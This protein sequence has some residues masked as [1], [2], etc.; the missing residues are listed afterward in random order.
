MDTD[1][2]D[3]GGACDGTTF[4]FCP[5]EGEVPDW[6]VEDCGDC[7]QNDENVFDLDDCGV[8]GGPGEIEQC[9]DADGDGWGNSIITYIICEDA[10][11]EWV[12]DCT[13]IEDTVYCESNVIVDGTCI[14]LSLNDNLIPDN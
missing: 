1:N 3:V 7:D 6:A 8:C 10:D 9:L 4:L 13:D 2:D 12:L 14:D 5:V 11:D